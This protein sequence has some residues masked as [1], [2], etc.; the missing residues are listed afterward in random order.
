MVKYTLHWNAIPALLPPFFVTLQALWKHSAVGFFSAM[1]VY[2]GYA[3]RL[4]CSQTKSAPVGKY[5]FTI[6][7]E[8]ETMPKRIQKAFNDLRWSFSR[9]W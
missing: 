2:D 7:F 8:P 9:K 6:Y 5:V 4:Q 1:L 3:Q